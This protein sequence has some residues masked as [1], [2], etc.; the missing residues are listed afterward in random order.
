MAWLYCDAEREAGSRLLR[1]ALDSARNRGYGL[2]E[3]RA[4]QPSNSPA[5]S[6][7]PTVNPSRLRQGEPVATIVLDGCDIHY[8]R[9]GEGPLMALTPG[10][11]LGGDAIRDTAERLAEHC[12]VLLW[13]RRNTGASHVWFGLRAEQ[14]V[15]ADDLAALLR[16]L[17]LGPAYLAG[18]SAGARVSYLTAIHH[19]DV[20]AGLAL[21]SVSG[22][23][24]AS[25]NLGYAYHTPF[26]HEAI[27]AGMEAVADTAFFRERIQAHPGNRDRLLATSPE[28]FGAAMRAWNESFYHRADTPV[29]A[30]TAAEL[31][32]IRCP[33]LVFEGNDDFHPAEA[34]TAMHGLV[35]GSELAPSPWGT[36]EWMGRYVGRLPGQVSDLYPRLVPA[37]VDFVVRVEAERRAGHPV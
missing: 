16:H 36:D 3:R 9:L 37:V 23:P 22:G 17:D 28:Q 27:R 18:A 1:R 31:R 35:E 14:Q 34:S 33:T 8:E 2:I 10:G 15:W 7:P 12:Q 4:A 32:S 21:W 29:I 20:V 25:Q 11:R 26:I 30:A 19:P 13:D 5:F 6:R 24:F